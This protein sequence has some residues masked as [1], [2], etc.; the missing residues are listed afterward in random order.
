MSDSSTSRPAPVPPSTL[1]PLP[2]KSVPTPATASA[3]PRA[4][5]PPAESDA[6]ADGPQHVPTPG[7]VFLT[8]RVIDQNTFDQLSKMLREMVREASKQASGLRASVSQAARVANELKAAEQGQQ[9]NLDLAAAALKRIEEKA[10]K[11]EQ[12]LDRV[13]NTAAASSALERKADEIVSRRVEGFEAR[14]SAILTAHDARLR[15]LEQR[16]TSASRRLEERVLEVQKDAQI[17]VAP[18]FTRLEAMCDRAEALIGKPARAASGSEPGAASGET[19]TGTPY[20]PNSLGEMLDRAES[21]RTDAAF[22]Q[23]QLDAVRQQ[24]DHARS[25]LGESLNDMCTM[26][27][28]LTE[29]AD[30]LRRESEHARA[31]ASEVSSD[32]DQRASAVKGG[33]ERTLAEAREQAKTIDTE[34]S[35]L[36]EQGKQTQQTTALAMRVAETTIGQLRAVITQL[37][38]WQGLVAS[39]PGENADDTLAALPEPVRRV[40][41]HTRVELKRDLGSVASALRHLAASADDAGERLV[42]TTTTMQSAVPG[43]SA[44]Q[45]HRRGANAPDETTSAEAAEPVYY[46]PLVPVTRVNVQTPVV[47]ERSSPIAQ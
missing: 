10:V 5:E 43:V 36:I 38:P 41:E 35:R 44:A 31:V 1:K 8:P 15:D 40:I 6:L 37:E 14:L 29:R 20:A 9:D 23:K 33:V 4:A 18:V 12:L 13:Q 2:T 30:D 27:D 21:L 19:P 22:A 39:R 42:T 28:R 16:A 3:A 25:I 34:V 32:I 24:A 26:I 11:A 46:P 7:E 17:A 47:I 45:E